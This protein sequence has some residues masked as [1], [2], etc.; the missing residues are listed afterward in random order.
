MIVSLLLQISHGFEFFIQTPSSGELSPQG[1]CISSLLL[2]SPSSP[3]GQYIS[4]YQYYIC[5]V[6]LYLEQLL[7]TPLPCHPVLLS[8]LA[9][10]L[11]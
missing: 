7:S 3:P 2:A 11:P 1:L 4:E 10:S 8:L 6:L 9:Q 5:L